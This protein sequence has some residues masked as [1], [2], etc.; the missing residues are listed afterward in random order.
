MAFKA[1]KI[2]KN[3]NQKIIYA[4]FNNINN[5]NNIGFRNMLISHIQSMNMPLMQEL[6]IYICDIY[7]I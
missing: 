1:S 5:N 6:F 3:E 4:L 7:Q 2:K